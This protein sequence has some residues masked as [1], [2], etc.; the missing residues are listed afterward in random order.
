MI[1]GRTPAAWSKVSL[2]A[3]SGSHS[4]FAQRLGGSR[5]LAGLGRDDSRRAVAEVA[6]ELRR[7]MRE[8]PDDGERA[9]DQDGPD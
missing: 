6:K 8:G 9:G 7:R 3:T 2:T 5:A 4:T 1:A